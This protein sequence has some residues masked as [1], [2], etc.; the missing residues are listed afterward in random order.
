MLARLQNAIVKTKERYGDA[1]N[2]SIV[3]NKDIQLKVASNLERAYLGDAP[4][5]SIVSKTYSQNVMIA[6]IV[7]QLENVN[8][9]CGVSKKM[10]P[11]QMNELAGIIAT[12]YYYLK[13]TELHLFLHRLKSG[14]Y[15][16][17]YGV[18][19]AMKI[20]EGLVQF[21][22]ERLSEINAFERER[23]KHEDNLKREEWA[24]TGISRQEYEKQKAEKE[25]KHER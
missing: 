21:S 6:W 25:Q 12:E 4:S 16:Q 20:T 23:K 8:D 3:F 14:R 19:D 7:V 1:V 24:R 11:A 10:S 9:F 17:F 2:F 5:L 15:G 18:I 13:V 22:K